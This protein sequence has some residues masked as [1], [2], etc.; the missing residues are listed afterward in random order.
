MTEKR[1]WY[2]VRTKPRQEARA[3]LEFERQGLEVYLPMVLTR[4]RHAR[5]V[6]WE[7]RPFLPGYLF[8]HLA[9]EERCWTRIRS[10]YGAIGVVHFGLHHP[11]V[12]DEA[13]AMMRASENEKGMIETTSTPLV[14]FTAGERVRVCG[15]SLEGLEGIFQ[16]MRGQDR[17]MVFLD[18]LGRRIHAQVAVEQLIVA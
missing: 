15:G 18:W 2:A 16:E 7:A 1:E 4:I 13:I 14:P 17:A 5:K 10:T 12:P 8:L 9:P 3:R 11:S 6:D